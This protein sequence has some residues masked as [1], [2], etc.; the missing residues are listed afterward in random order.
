MSRSRCGDD[1]SAEC[2]S[3]GA[4]DVEARG[5]PGDAGGEVARRD[6]L[7]RNR[8]PRGI[9]Q[10]RTKTHQKCQ[11]QQQGGSDLAGQRKPA[12]SGGGQYH[13]ALGEEQ[14][15]AAIDHVGKCA[16][17]QHYH[18]DGDAARGLHQAHH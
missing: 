3:D 18:E 10:H 6:D 1:Q 7:G 8:L 12:E 16:R 15:L 13:P 5:V 11:H 4:R 9:V 2:R 17:G 14:Q